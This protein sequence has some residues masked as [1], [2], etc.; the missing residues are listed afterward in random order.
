MS[1]EEGIEVDDSDHKIIPYLKDPKVEPSDEV[2]IGLFFTG[3]GVP[4][5]SKLYINFFSLDLDVEKDIEFTEN[6]VKSIDEEKDELYVSTRDQDSNTYEMPAEKG[7]TIITD[8][9][10][11]LFLHKTENPDKYTYKPTQGELASLEAPLEIKFK[12]S[13]EIKPGNYQINFALTY[14]DGKKVE[15]VTKE[16]VN[17][18]VMDWYERN[19][20]WIKPISII[21]AL[22]TVTTA[23]LSFSLDIIQ[24]F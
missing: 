19:I 4:D 24:F 14:G 7:K 10:P 16:E 20:S 2:E 12:L 17:V 22:I 23:I 9:G 21:L 15:N 3:Y 5:K 18:H 8:V 13:E 11:H 6:I 1:D